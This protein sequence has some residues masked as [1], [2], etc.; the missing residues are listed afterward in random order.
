MLKAGVDI[1]RINGAH[2]DDAEHRRMIAL[3]RDVSRRLGLATAILLDLP[4]PKL[5]LGALAEEPIVLTAGRTVTLVCGRTQQTDERLPLPDRFVAR[6]VKRGSRIFL[7]DGIVALT[8][9]AVHGTEVVC[10]VQAGGELRSRKGVNLPNVALPIPSLTKRDRELAA[11]AVREGVDY[12]GLSFVRAAKNVR[13]LRR[14][15]AKRAPNIGI[16]AKIEKP[17]ALDELDAIIDAADA[18]MVARGDLGIEMSFDRIPVV[19]RRILAACLR[20]GKP[21]ITATQMMESMV[22]STRPTRA[23]ATDVAGAVW[24][25]TDAVMLSEETSIGQNPATAVR[26]MARIARAA[27]REMPPLPEPEPLRGDDARQAQV[28]ANAAGRLV[29]ELGVRAILTPTRSGRTALNVSRMRPAAMIIAPTEEEGIAR[30]M[31]LYW[32]VRPLM[33]PHFETVD[34]LLRSAEQ[35]A[36]KARLVRAGER[37]VLA[38]GAHGRKDD[39]TRLVEVRKV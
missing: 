6:A 10:R 19:Q 29:A 20:A 28:L 8:V 26:A 30:R 4:G 22:R 21:A 35:A 23:E 5:R 14:L 18:V 17:E 32:G 11:F 33:M 34:E 1:V 15:L 9:R 13:D 31:Q 39:I 36:R 25:G 2:G 38:S 27:E 37:I 7:N 12:V 3:V 24:E 16:I